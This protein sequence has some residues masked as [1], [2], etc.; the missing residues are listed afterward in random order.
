MPRVCTICNH[1]SRADIDRALVA[2]DSY[3]NIAV[4]FSVSVSALTRHKADHLPE[5]LVEATKAQQASDAIDVM[6]ELQRCFTRINKL[7]DACD[8]WLTDPEDP[9]RYTLEPRSNEVKVIFSEDGPNGKPVQKKE[10]L[11]TLL[12]R[13]EGKQ[14]LYSEVRH[15]DPRELVLKTAAQL[16]SQQELLAKLIGQL[17]QEGTV[18]VHISAEWIEIKAVLMHALQPYPEARTAVAVALTG[19]EHGN[20]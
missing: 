20:G 6:I 10:R 4:R 17:Q 2:N 12:G 15:S 14:V 19:V 18:N 8:A 9:T 11:S 1:A 5:A 13:L 16:E 3:R 7:F